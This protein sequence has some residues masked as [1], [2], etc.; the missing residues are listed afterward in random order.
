[1]EAST[2]SISFLVLR[3]EFCSGFSCPETRYGGFLA[4][5]EREPSR[6]KEEERLDR[7]DSIVKDCRQFAAVHIST[8]ACEHR[9]G[10]AMSKP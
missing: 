4:Y 8:A 7:S 5:H 2:R 10:E 6:I 1:M 9:D 3:M